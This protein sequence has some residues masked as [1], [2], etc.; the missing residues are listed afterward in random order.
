VVGRTADDGDGGRPKCDQDSPGWLSVSSAGAVAG[1]LQPG[2][3][4]R[5]GGGGEGGEGVE[6][7]GRRRSQVRR[8]S[9]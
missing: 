1:V 7:E 6:G 5:A 4:Y 8:P 9:V 3:D 2:L